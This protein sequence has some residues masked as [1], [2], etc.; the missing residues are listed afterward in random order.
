[1]NCAVITPIGPGHENLFKECQAS[2][3]AAAKTN[4]GPFGQILHLSV[5][6]TKVQLGRSAARNHGVARA[7]SDGADWI[8]FLDAD[9]LMHPKAF[10]AVAENIHAY[11]AVWGAICEMP[12]GS[13]Q[14][15]IRQ[16]QD[17]PI[18]NVIDVLKVDPFLSLQMG[19]FVKSKIALDN[20]FNVEMNTGEDFDYYLRIWH[21]Y[22]CVKLADPLFVNRR[23]MH[24]VG[25]KSATGLDWNKAV[26]SVMYKFAKEN[27]DK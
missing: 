15:C 24:S 11:D 21:R 10:D 1:M 25:P 17:I 27:F 12:K 26:M 2:V 23:G 4:S 14:I 13:Q 18:R 9:D 3:A 20:P 19:H 16:G 5:D 6:D 22:R 8:F 7:V